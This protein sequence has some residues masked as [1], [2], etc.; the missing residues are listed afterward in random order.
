[1]CVCLAKWLTKK[2]KIYAKIDDLYNMIRMLFILAAEDWIL[3]KLS[4][5]IEIVSLI[6]FIKKGNK[7]QQK[8]KWLEEPPPSR[9]K[10][11]KIIELSKI[12]ATKFLPPSMR[13]KVYFQ[14]T[15]NR[16]EVFNKVTKEREGRVS[17]S[18][19]PNS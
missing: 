9:L 10:N 18:Y 14:Q 16:L 1:M 6:L 4:V 19:G 3:E 17:H 13:D 8:L 2:I 11:G 7:L 12:W 15:S 5:I